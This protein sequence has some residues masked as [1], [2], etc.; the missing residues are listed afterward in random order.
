MQGRSG[1][2]TR[3]EVKRKRQEK[4]QEK[5]NQRYKENVWLKWQGFVGRKNW[6]EEAKPL[7]GEV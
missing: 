7:S 6:G 4:D 5:K 2:W 3:E 1:E